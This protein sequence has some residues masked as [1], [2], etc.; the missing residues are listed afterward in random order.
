MYIEAS[1]PRRPGDKARLTSRSYTP[2][3]TAAQCLEFWY[4]MFGIDTGTLNV[5]FSNSG[6]LGSPMFT[7]QGNSL[8]SVCK[9][10]WCINE[11]NCLRS[12]DGFTSWSNVRVENMYSKKM[13]LQ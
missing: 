5:Y 13:C 1:A 12:I 11:K 2:S 8:T 7:K 10:T 4:N 3:G 9:C 6:T